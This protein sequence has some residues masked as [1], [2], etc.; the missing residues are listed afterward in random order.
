MNKLDIGCYVEGITTSPITY[1]GFRNKNYMRGW[2][3]GTSPGKSMIFIN[4]DICREATFVGGHTAI[5]KAESV[6][7]IANRVEDWYNVDINRV[8]PGEKVR[9][10]KG[11]VYRL[12]MYANDCDRHEFGDYGQVAVYISECG[13]VWAR[14]IIEFNSLN[15]RHTGQTYRFETIREE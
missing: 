4:A 3:T 7:P 11:G 6:R 15:P 14:D 9:H 8:K 10:F 12:L 13:E 5:L 1:P 2:I